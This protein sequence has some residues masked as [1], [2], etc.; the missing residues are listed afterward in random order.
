[1]VHGSDCGRPAT[2]CSTTSL[3]SGTLDKD[4]VCVWGFRGLC[5]GCMEYGFGGER[6]LH[7][8]KGRISLSRVPS[9]TSHFRSKSIS[10]SFFHSPSSPCI[11]PPFSF[12]VPPSLRSSHTQ[13]DTMSNL[14]TRRSLAEPV[15]Q[16]VA[17][18]LQQLCKT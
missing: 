7:K 8:V 3:H 13:E 15:F 2:V 18:A 14:A 12:S 17:R 5:K 11:S 4:F 6:V 16:S 1:M 10:Q 9:S